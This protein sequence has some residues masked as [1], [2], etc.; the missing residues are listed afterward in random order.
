MATFLMTMLL[1]GLLIGFGVYHRYKPLPAGISDETA[2]YPACNAR[3][4]I[5]HRYVD[6]RG[7]SRMRREIAPAMLD[8]IGHARERI[9]LDAFLFN[10]HM[11]HRPEHVS[12]AETLTCALVY[13]C[14]AYPRL[15]ITVVIDPI[16]SYYGAQWPDHFRRLQA[17]GV[18]VVETPLAR[19]RDSNPLWSV[20]WR[21]FMQPWG[22]RVDGG[23]L[24]N[25][26]GTGKITL[27]SWLTLLNFRANH[28]K[29][30]I[31]DHDGGWQGLVASGNPHDASS[32]HTNVGLRFTG[33]AARA[34]LDQEHA[35]IGLANGQTPLLA[36]F[37]RFP[38]TPPGNA[39]RLR[40]LTESRIREAALGLIEKAHQGD[41]LDFALFYLSHR[42]IIHALMQ[43]HRRGC[44]I[45]VL[46]DPNKDAFGRVKSG[47]PNRQVAME[48]HRLGIRVRW[49]RTHGEQFHCK[50][51]RRETRDGNVN[52]IVG[53]ANFTRRNL[54]DLNLET[55]CQIQG[56][57]DE[58]ALRVASDWFERCW[59]NPPGFQCSVPYEVWADEAR[60]R[61]LLYRFAERSGWSSF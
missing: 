3:F 61:Y 2:W 35:L 26:I 51:L 34:L 5:D 29:V 7:R 1:A 32:A 13:R 21:L 55:A 4:L 58:G 25:P 48:L 40:I 31:A 38:E 17:A 12:V 45:R 56:H 43:A 44:Q 22:N 28:R 53:S 60:L 30:M 18:E 37:P 23:W 11:A 46:L 19:L 15:R 47:L 49:Y 54:D 41:S 33:E 20:P 16:N 36:S 9:V 14:R 10:P 8:M 59:F 6:T 50:Y 52:L 39:P 27:R 57:E 24:P 42:R